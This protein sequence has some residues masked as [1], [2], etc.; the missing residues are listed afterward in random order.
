V[1]RVLTLS[2]A[3]LLSPHAAAG[4]P[5]ARVLRVCSDPNNLPFSNDRGEGFENRLA[6]LL[7][8]E[9]DARVEYTFWAQRRGFLRNTLSAERCDVVMG[10][11]SALE[12]VATTRPYY[13]STYVFVSRRDRKLDI[14]TLD[15]PRLRELTIG[16]PLIGDD[17]AN[18][19]PAHALARRGIVQNLRGYSVYGDYSQDNPPAELVKAVARGDVDLAIAWGPLAG[20]F[21]KQSA[22]RLT[23]R[24]VRGEQ[25]QDQPLSFAIAV[26][27][28]KRDSELRNELDAALA[29]RAREVRALLERYGVPRVGEP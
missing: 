5:P 4:E 11:P 17:Y 19:P 29:R 15:D 23:L 14:T 27:V 13:R 2:L 28:R 20:F 9:L 22:T 1:R 16:V 25:Q 3:L 24:P 8:R 12:Q 21:A 7:A 6:E 18:T 26:G 10:V